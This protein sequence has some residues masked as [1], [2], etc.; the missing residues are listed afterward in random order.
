MEDEK[1]GFTVLTISFQKHKTASTI[2]IQ[3]KY[4]S[5]IVLLSFNQKQDLFSLHK[6]IQSGSLQT[7]SC[8]FIFLTMKPPE[9]FSKAL[10]SSVRHCHSLQYHNVYLYNFSLPLPISNKFKY[11]FLFISHRLVL[12]F[13]IRIQHFPV[14]YYSGLT[15]QWC[16]SEETCKHPSYK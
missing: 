5:N 8:I 11:V 14:K 9:Y 7:K 3:R 15:S 16:V 10:F 1:Q 2:E 6:K 4:N 13:Q 12:F